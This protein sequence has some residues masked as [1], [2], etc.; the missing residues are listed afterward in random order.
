M[1][2]LMEIRREEGEV[3][4]AEA[5]YRLREWWDERE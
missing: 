4:K 5:T 1:A 2:F 3:S